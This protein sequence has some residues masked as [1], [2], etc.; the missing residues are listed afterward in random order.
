[1]APDLRVPATAV[2]PRERPA[3]VRRGG[4]TQ[5]AEGASIHPPS[6]AGLWLFSTRERSPSP[7][8]FWSVLVGK[9]MG[10]GGMEN[11]S[12]IPWAV[13]RGQGH[14]DIDLEKGKG[15]P[16]PQFVSCETEIEKDPLP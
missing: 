16:S 15:Y 13:G 14:H 1:M 4:W 12:N 3:S 6:P 7:Q 9:V 8:F 2:A 5:R 10:E 11:P